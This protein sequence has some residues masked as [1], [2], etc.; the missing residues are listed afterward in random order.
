MSY[1][2]LCNGVNREG[3]H[4][5]MIAAARWQALLAILLLQKKTIYEINTSW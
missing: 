4:K 2:I 5:K 3:I 1:R